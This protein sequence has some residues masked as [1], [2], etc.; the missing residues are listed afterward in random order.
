MIF[1]LYF[2][3]LDVKTTTPV[4]VSTTAPVEHQSV[5]G[6][7]TVKIGT[8]QSDNPLGIKIKEITKPEEIRITDDKPKNQLPKST[9]TTA[10][11]NSH[12][13]GKKHK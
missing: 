13:A 12:S 2:T 6:N 1:C 8:P 3:H 10:S 5:D 11:G 7:D 9:S 4:S